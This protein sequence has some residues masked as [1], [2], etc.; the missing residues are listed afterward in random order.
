[1]LVSHK[2]DNILVNSGIEKSYPKRKLVNS[3]S[4]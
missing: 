1:M 2:Q 4:L 3:N